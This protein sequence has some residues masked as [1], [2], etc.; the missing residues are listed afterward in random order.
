M[1]GIIF[2]MPVKSRIR[3]F[4]EKITGKGGTG[5]YMGRKIST[6]AYT[7]LPTLK[8]VKEKPQKVVSLPTEE[9]VL[10]YAQGMLDEND[11]RYDKER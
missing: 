10:E 7:E 4:A 11:K 1:P 2:D 8:D 3:K 6:S 9:M 5:I